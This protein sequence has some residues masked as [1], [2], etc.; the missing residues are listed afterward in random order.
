L[1]YGIVVYSIPLKNCIISALLS[2]LLLCVWALQPTN[3]EHIEKN[4]NCFIGFIR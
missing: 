1:E 2:T 3:K 4:K